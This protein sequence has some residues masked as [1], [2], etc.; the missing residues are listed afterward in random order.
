MRVTATI[1]GRLLALAFGMIALM[2][3]VVAGWWLAFN[4]LKVNGPVYERI[5]R[6]G[7]LVAD[8]LP[9]P[10]YIIEAY[11]ETTL[12][13]NAPADEIAGH[14]ER[15]RALEGEYQNRHVFWLN[16]QLAP[17]LAGL[18]LEGSFL[19]AQR[20]FREANEVFFPALAR[21]ERERAEASFAALTEAYHLHRAA[22]D[23]VVI[24][25]QRQSR[26]VE[27]EA[28]A[29][30][31]LA[32]LL[33]GLLSAIGALAAL[34]GTLTV[35]RG[36][37]MPM[38]RLSDEVQRLG[39]GDTAQPVPETGR[40]DEIGP[41]ARALES[42]RRSLIEVVS[43][44]HH[45]QQESAGREARA[46]ALETASRRFESGIVAVVEGVSA[47]VR[48]LQDSASSLSA[49]AAQTE[50]Q[51]V[52]VFQ[53]SE[54]AA[55]SVE[56]VELSG[57]RLSGAIAEI[58][59]QVGQSGTIV[60]NAASATDGATRRLDGLT[61]AVER[62]GAVLTLINDIAA[63]TNLLALNATIEAA[64]AGEAGKGFAVVAGEVKSLAGQTARAT[65]DIA[66][67]IGAV[68]E[69]TRL[70]VASIDGIAST[71]RCVADL[72]MAI[73]G[74]VELQNAAAAEIACKVVEATEGTRGVADNIGDVTR[75]ASDTGRIARVVLA[76]A[77]TLETHSQRLETE[78]S[79]FLG[80]IAAAHR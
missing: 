40:A 42:W 69:E 51:S 56:A 53:A 13:L 22:I 63:Q 46:L 16:R 79:R 30:D 60:S 17:D 14:R 54:R 41:L 25:A 19:P 5:A 50:R 26:S 37:I 66:G 47:A 61:G 67:Q 39:Q 20:F 71:I 75:A 31:R 49:T 32:K 33:V 74:A 62:I 29:D 15:L 73:S 65:D 8:I 28:A 52:A 78:I 76:A 36:I 18:F 11:L 7:E 59:R 3:A 4:H 68:R 21:G 10:E 57:Q 70:T 80:E 58:A 6:T 48:Q 2:V 9:P 38:R 72:S 44:R 12:A 34:V 23:Q 1:R 77:V 27:D 55:A 35:A 64:R 45:E 43:R 24:A